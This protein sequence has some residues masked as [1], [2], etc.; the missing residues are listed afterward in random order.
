MRDDTAVQRNLIIKQGAFFLAAASRG[1]SIATLSAVLGV[2]ASTLSS[3]IDKPSRK[4]S[5]MP[6]SLFIR[7]AGIKELTDLAS[8]LIEDSDHRLCPLDPT[9]TNWDGLAAEAAGLVQE[10]C[11]ARADGNIN[12]Q[13]DARLRA[14]TRKLIADAQGAVGA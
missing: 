9:L 3:Y 4:A 7:I 11:L 5:Q 13:E 8:M 10:V 6:L 2:S 14:R 12:H 1:Y